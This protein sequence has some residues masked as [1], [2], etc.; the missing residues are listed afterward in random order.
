M[1]QKHFIRVKSSEVKNIF[2]EEQRQIPYLVF[3]FLN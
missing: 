3:A 2:N 1:L